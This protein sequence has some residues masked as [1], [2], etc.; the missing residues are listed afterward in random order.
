MNCGCLRRQDTLSCDHIGDQ[1][2]ISVEIMG[3]R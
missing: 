1:I 2:L 3:I